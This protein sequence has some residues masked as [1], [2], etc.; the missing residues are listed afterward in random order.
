M[1]K[2]ALHIFHA[3]RDYF[4]LFAADDHLAVARRLRFHLGGESCMLAA[5]RT[6]GAVAA[7]PKTQRVQQ[8]EQLFGLAVDVTDEVE[9]VGVGH[10]D[11]PPC[12]EWRA[13]S[14]S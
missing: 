3:A 10:T 6:N 13:R 11:T 9:G 14:A 7:L 8:P 1:C 5:L 12:A 2:K 4:Q